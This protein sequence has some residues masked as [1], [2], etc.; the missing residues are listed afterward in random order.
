[1]LEVYEVTGETRY[2]DAAPS[3]GPLRVAIDFH[4]AFLREYSEAPGSSERIFFMQSG[5]PLVATEALQ[6]GRDLRRV[7]RGP[8]MYD[9]RYDLPLGGRWNTPELAGPS[10]LGWA[11]RQPGVWLASVLEMPYAN[12]AGA[13]VTP[14]SARAFCA[15]FATALHNYLKGKRDSSN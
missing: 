9:G 12:A 5:N 4:C 6:F 2:L 7:Q 3:N 10:F 13:A 15:D 14:E 1:M 11:E 8:L